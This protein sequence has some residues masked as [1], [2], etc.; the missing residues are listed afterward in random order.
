M[1]PR[2]WHAALVVVL[3][4]AAIFAS[5]I[6]DM[7]RRMKYS[8]LIRNGKDY[9]REYAMVSVSH[10]YGLMERMDRIASSQGTDITDLLERA[11]GLLEGIAE[12][13]ITRE[14]LPEAN[15]KWL[16]FEDTLVEMSRRII[17]DRIRMN[18][19]RLRERY[20][21]ASGFEREVLGRKVEMLDEL[22]VD[23]NY[24]DPW[25]VGERAYGIINGETVVSMERFRAYGRGNVSISMDAGVIELWGTGTYW[26][27]G[28]SIVDEFDEKGYVRVEGLDI[29]LNFSGEGKVVARGIGVAHV[30]GSGYY[31]SGEEEGP[32]PVNGTEKI[33][34]AGE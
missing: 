23:I 21:S 22:L 14:T 5:S 4:S 25:K 6:G 7:A 29:M 34:I 32:W 18:M 27:R 16:E 15:G 20:R 17:A 2:P 9:Y 31:S 11:A 1:E 10:G 12:M 3:I 28:G 24:L 13:E 8:V 30:T 33:V 26:A 19:D